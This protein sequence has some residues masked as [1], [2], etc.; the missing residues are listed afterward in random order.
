MGAAGPDLLGRLFDAHAPALTLYARQWCVAADDAVQEAFVRL[1][2]QPCVPDHT[3]AW[4][5]RVVRNAA[6]SASR[7][8]RRRQ[9]RETRAAAPE[10]WFDT[11]PDPIDA[12]DASRLVAALDADQREAVV[13]RIWGGLNFDEIATLQGCSLATAHRRYHAGLARLREQMP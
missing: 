1:A 3:V 13:A 5:F 2:R 7:T 8:E 4:L 9:S 11:G 10:V 6:I 12:A